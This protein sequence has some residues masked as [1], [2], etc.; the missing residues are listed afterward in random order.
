MRMRNRI[1]GCRD[2][3]KPDLSAQA[4]SLRIAVELVKAERPCVGAAEAVGVNRRF[5][6]NSVQAEFEQGPAAPDGES[7]GR[8]SDD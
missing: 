4:E 5:V 3:C 1:A 2:F 7:A 8:R 6:N